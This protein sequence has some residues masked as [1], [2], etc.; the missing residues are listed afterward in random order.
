MTTRL[1]KAPVNFTV[2]TELPLDEPK[3]AKVLLEDDKALGVDRV[4]AA[5]LSYSD[6]GSPLHN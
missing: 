1:G 2:L 4:V 6:I 5:R 3:M